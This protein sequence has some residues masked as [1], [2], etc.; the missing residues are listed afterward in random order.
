MSSGRWSS[1]EFAAYL[2]EMRTKDDWPADKQDW[3]LEPWERVQQK[4]KKAVYASVERPA[5]GKFSDMMSIMLVELTE[6]AI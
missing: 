1:D 3:P 6:D 2:R 4:M 5:S